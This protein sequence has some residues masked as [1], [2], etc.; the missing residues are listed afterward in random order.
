ME[1]TML[2]EGE[3]ITAN[4][5][6]LEYAAWAKTV[7]KNV[8]PEMDCAKFVPKAVRFIREEAEKRGY[9]KLCVG[10]SGGVD[11]AVTSALAIK[12][13]LDTSVITVT[14]E[15]FIRKIDMIDAEKIARHLGIF[16]EIVDTT[17]VCR[18]ITALGLP[19]THHLIMGMRNTIIKKIAEERG[20]LLLGTSN[21]TEKIARLFSSNSY[22]GQ[23]FPLASLLKGHVYALA[24]YLGLPEFIT[25]KASHGGIEGGADD[26]FLG[27]NHTAFD[28]AAAMCEGSVAPDNIHVPK[29]LMQHIKANERAANIFFNF[30]EL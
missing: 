17:S 9:K 27:M 6:L 10:L 11:S 14:A 24:G 2:C 29:K 1:P 23:I 25:T 13:E 26:L 19:G 5:E 22:V 21:K 18:A 4:D 3:G 28:F 15:T 30:A 16:Q 7:P 12:T 8:L 20:A